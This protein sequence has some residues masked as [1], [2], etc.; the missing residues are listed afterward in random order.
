MQLCI[1]KSL[2]K[3]DEDTSEGHVIVMGN[4]DTIKVHGKGVVDLQF[5]SDKKLVLTDVLHIPESRH[6]EESC[7]N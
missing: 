1:D 3:T 5:T 7:I 4:H 6:E 2:F